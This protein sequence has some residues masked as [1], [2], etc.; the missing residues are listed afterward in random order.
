[1]RRVEGSS[2]M[3][4]NRRE[5]GRTTVGRSEGLVHC[6]GWL[7]KIPGDWNGSRGHQRDRNRLQAGSGL[8][9]VLLCSFLGFLVYFFF[10]YA[11]G[12]FLFVSFP[13]FLCY[14]LYVCFP[15]FLWSLSFA[16]FSSLFLCSCSFC[17]PWLSSF[18]S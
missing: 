1:M 3:E 13:F 16:S 9:S 2:V 5:E 15:F 6:H 4:R 12:R 10:S 11:S 17:F 18:I 8:F 14:F 7:A